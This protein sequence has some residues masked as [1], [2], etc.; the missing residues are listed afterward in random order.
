MTIRQK[1]ILVF[2]LL[3]TTATASAVPARPGLRRTLT[4]RSGTTIEV[5]L[6]GDEH[7]HYW[8]ADDGRTFDD[9]GRLITSY[10]LEQRKLTAAWRH[11]KSGQR[12]AARRQQQ[13]TRS[14]QAS[15][16]PIHPYT[17]ERRGLIILVEFADKTF[18]EGHN[19]TLYN[20]IANEPGFTSA[21]GF[22]GSISDYFYDQSR[23][24]FRLTFDVIGPVTMEKDFA[25]YGQ[26]DNKGYDMHPGKMVIEACNA[27]ADDV[28][29]ADYDWDGD[30][31]VDQVMIIYA[32]RGE[33]SGGGTD[34]I[35]PHEW[36][37]T[38]AEG[39]PITL[40]DVVINTY[41]CSCELQ[42]ST[43]I[44]GIGTTCHEFSHCLGLPDFYDTSYGG[45]YGMGNWSLMASG[46][47]NNNAFT[48]AGYTSFERMCCGWLTPIELTDATEVTDMKA[49]TEDGEAY[50]LYNDAYPNEFYLLENR[51]KV[52]WDASLSSVGLLILH[53]DYDEMVWYWNMVNTCADY[54]EEEYYG[55]GAVNDH[56]R[57]TIFHA[58]NYENGTFGAPYPYDKNDSL[59]ATS[60]PSAMLYHANSMEAYKMN[61]AITGI[62][63]S[64][65]RT[66]SFSFER[67]STTSTEGTTLFY[68]SFDHCD[69]AGGNDGKWDGNGVG[70][71]SFV[72]DNDGW[73]IGAFSKGYGAYQCAKF[74]KSST[75]GVATT[76][77]FEMN[78]RATLT[79][80]AAPWSDDGTTLSLSISDG[81]ATITPQTVTMTKGQ[82]TEFTATLEGSG[83]VKIEFCP[84]KRF[85]LDEVKIIQGATTAI[86]PV[87]ETLRESTHIYTLDGRYVGTDFST[88]PH[89]VYI[90]KGKKVKK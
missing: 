70:N 51:Q 46:S 8:Q 53:V 36:N 73:N 13:T 71:G 87:F 42:S 59:T 14:G 64:S 2:L 38:E 19:Q 60:R 48:P 29:F 52:G 6:Q 16:L 26:N 15:T 49:L 85:F 21:D 81:N 12:R 80:K 63:K 41:A 54:T 27:I 84:N 43:K 34:T 44:D 55:P 22:N 3:L 57:C 61:A 30:G 50:I 40:D 74:G 7:L 1:A 86:S 56:Q 68:E 79:F 25:Y 33:N 32:G 77:A 72:T 89:S 67:R 66:V 69:G 83:N 17:D 35:W 4:L 9:E 11:I 78:G 58:N 18:L 76:P 20:S 39:A 47:Y 31:E 10:D 75:V 62:K 90:F 82:W 5:T 37:L 88:L 24:L 45:N 65:D 23:G 28:N